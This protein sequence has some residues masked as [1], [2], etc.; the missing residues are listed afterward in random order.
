[1]FQLIIPVIIKLSNLVP[2]YLVS[3]PFN[4]Q[5]TRL[6]LGRAKV[7]QVQAAK[8]TADAKLLAGEDQWP[9]ESWD[10]WKRMKHVQKYPK[11]MISEK[12]K[13]EHVKDPS[14]G[15]FLDVR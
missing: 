2:S 14:C 8:E 3:L 5:R 12:K 6:E 13:S 10:V 1:M 15:L 7:E 9:H 4:G 11:S